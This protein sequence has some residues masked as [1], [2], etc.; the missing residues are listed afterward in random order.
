MRWNRLIVMNFQDIVTYWQGL[1]RDEHGRWIHPD[2]E[3]VF[4]SARHSFNLDFPVS[5]Y[6]GDILLAPVIILGANAG[7]RADV[8]PSE[9]PDEAAIQ[10]YINRV[11]APSNTDWSSVAPYYASVNYGPLIADGLAVLVNA[12]A[13]R[14][15]KISKEP[16]NRKLIRRLPSVAMTRRWLLEVVRPLLAEGQRIVVVKRAGLWELPTDFRILPGV[17]IDPAPISPQLTGAAWTA[18][19]S[20]LGGSEINRNGHF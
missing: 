6:V 4:D 15:P 9:F 12:C 11:R 13:Y 8:T 10:T 16:E 5:P 2:D 18:V 7:Y 20:R 19:Q 3:P 17:T 14:S 1:H